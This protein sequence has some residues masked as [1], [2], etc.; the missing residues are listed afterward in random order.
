[1]EFQSVGINLNGTHLG[2][3]SELAADLEALRRAGPDFVEVC[4]HGLGVILGG[5]LDE[6]R[7]QEVAGVLADAGPAYTVHAPHRLNL[8]DPA[9]FELHRGALEASVRFAAMIGADVVVCHAGQRVNTRDARHSLREQLA[10]EREALRRI[11]ELAG[12]LGVTLAVENSYPERPI[13]RGEV[14]AY[15]AWPSELAEQVAA[16]DHPAVGIC[17]DVGHAAVAAS[18]FGFDYL[19]ECAAAAPLVRHVHLHDNLGRPE[20]AEDG[21]AFGLAERSAYGFGDLHLPPGRGSLPLEQLP[22]L[23]R[24]S[25]CVELRADLGH[26]AAEA[27]EAARHLGAP[28]VT[29]APA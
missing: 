18:F 29:R 6:R 28:E 14:Y 21:A 17:L 7:T 11:G 15:A 1:M 23:H 12:K 10:A 26:L 5:R 16:V 13:L 25:C 9:S 2:D 24:P 8:M 19:A 27:L 20:P 4:P 3:V 22:I